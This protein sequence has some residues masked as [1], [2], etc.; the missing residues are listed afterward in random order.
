MAYPTTA[1]GSSMALEQVRGLLK[2][3]TNGS[4]LHA[5][6]CA[7]IGKLVEEKPPDALATLETLSRY[8]KES[9]FSGARAPDSTESIVL[10]PKTAAE[11]EQWCS[12][13]MKLTETPMESIGNVKALCS[14]DNF[15]DNVS[16]FKWA[17]VGFGQQAS[18]QIHLSLRC[19]GASTPGLTKLRFWGKILGI[20]NDYFIAEGVI[21]GTG[22]AEDPVEARGKGANTFSYWVST[23]TNA[24]WVQLPLVRPDHIIAARKVKHLMTGDLESD[25]LTMPFFP[26]KE[27]HFLRA[28]IARISSSSCLAVDGYLQADDE[29]GD[30]KIA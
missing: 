30:G 11:K 27:K 26:G 17:G 4:S 3:D 16:M 10:D 23:G 7:I 6:L 25:V 28:Q 14:I 24:P 12:D 20:Q 13:I 15:L 5:Q 9:G 1:L 19:L 2:K 18:Y 8:L 21:D 22:E 29:G